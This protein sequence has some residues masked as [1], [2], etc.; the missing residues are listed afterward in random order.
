MERKR[1]VHP[2]LKDG[3]N[4]SSENK[5]NQ[6]GKLPVYST[7]FAT[8]FYNTSLFPN[9]AIR[10]PY[11]QYP[12][13][14]IHP[15]SRLF[16]PLSM[17]GNRG[18]HKN[19]CRDACVGNNNRSVSSAVTSCQNQSFTVT[20]TSREQKT[21]TTGSSC[22]TTFA[23]RNVI[24]YRHGIS[25]RENKGNDLVPSQLQIDTYQTNANVAES[26]NPTQ[27]ST[28]SSRSCVKYSKERVQGE[29][30]K[31]IFEHFHGKAASEEKHGHTER[32]ERQ[33]NRGTFSKNSFQTCKYGRGRGFASNS[34]TYTR[35]G[36][37]SCLRIPR[38][39][40]GEMDLVSH[41]YGFSHSGAG[42]RN[43]GD[44]HRFPAGFGR[45]KTVKENA[46]CVVIDY[47]MDK[48]D[49]SVK[50]R[51]NED[52]EKMETENF[53]PAS[54]R[55]LMRSADFS[56]TAV[57]TV[58]SSA[59]PDRVVPMEPCFQS[60]LELGRRWHYFHEADQH[61]GFAFT[62]VS[63]NV[64]ADRLLQE[65][66]GLYSGYPS[67]LLDW[68]YRKRNLMKEILDF[69]ADASISYLH[70]LFV[71]YNSLKKEKVNHFVSK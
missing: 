17:R 65:N 54:Q 56:Y 15:Y 48:K 49:L 66:F 39:A 42:V 33:Y 2:C 24:D 61:N 51:S 10:T 55:Q 20:S 44:S 60:Q 8:G 28:G 18:K 3:R 64:L 6:E 4:S 29:F 57:D 19:Q 47:A 36:N 32:T 26:R 70:H 62:V 45:G 9:S 34:E 53:Q 16:V 31:E 37:E 25:K 52:R 38:N 30:C 23:N 14:I 40:Q 1:I 71:S 13:P 50:Q 12:F 7:P 5:T 67:W 11:I 68:E 59:A 43:T 63:Y 22:R 41:K 21:N 69:R 46:Q 35:A 27:E 58:S